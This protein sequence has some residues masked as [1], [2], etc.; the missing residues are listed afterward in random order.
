MALESA[1]AELDK[2]GSRNRK[3]G[4]IPECS[5]ALL[6]MTIADCVDLPVHRTADRRD[7]QEL[8]R[9]ATDR[10]RDFSKMQVSHPENR[11]G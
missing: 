11:I 10:N 8:T 3:V 2:I 1:K 9:W 4:L 7:L 5:G 6:C